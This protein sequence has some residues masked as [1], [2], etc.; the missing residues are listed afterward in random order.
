[1][2]D[3]MDVEEALAKAHVGGYT[4][5]DGVYVR[6]YERRGDSAAQPV[7]HPKLGEKG[8]EVTIK[9]PHFAS[10]P[11]TWEHSDSVATFLP[12]GDAPASLNG[13]P[14]RRWRDHPTTDEGWDY[15]EG[16]NDDLAEPPFN[17]PPHKRA[18]AGVVI[19]EPDGRVW[20]ISP[21]N[22]FGGYKVTFPKGGAEEG[23]SLQANALKEAF[24]ESGL[25]VRI[26]GVIGDFERT[27]SVARMYRAVRV[28]GCPTDAGWETQ[29]V[30]LVPKDHM[31][32]HLNGWADYPVAEAV[33]AGPAPKIAPPPPAKKG[34]WGWDKKG[35][36]GGL[37]QGHK[38]PTPFPV[39]K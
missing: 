16:I 7:A 17:C 25:K 5:K 39:K 13:I 20:L 9:D 1:M 18:A 14:L 15:A 2:L 4:R 22:E 33:G 6:P 36:Q 32:E 19:E 27:T 37:F 29:S 21:T 12:D 31:Y 26:T 3:D 11:S 34:S 24:E 23:L 28:S 38:P 35:K 10:A 30:H 8:E